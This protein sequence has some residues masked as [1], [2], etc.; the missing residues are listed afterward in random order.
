MNIYIKERMGGLLEIRC[1]N[2]DKDSKVLFT[3]KVQTI[4]NGYGRRM[5]C[6]RIC[7]DEFND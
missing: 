4:P 5:D 6:C 2:C 7:C 3:L 1:D